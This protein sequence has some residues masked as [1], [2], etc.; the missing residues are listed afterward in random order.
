MDE[1]GVHDSF[2]QLIAE[3]SQNGGLSDAYEL[4]QLQRQLDEEGQGTMC[5]WQLTVACLRVE[6]WFYTRAGY[7]VIL[8]L[9][10]DIRRVG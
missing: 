2:N 6:G 5:V 1:E 3:Q 9:I 10:Q 8:I 7:Y 4:Q